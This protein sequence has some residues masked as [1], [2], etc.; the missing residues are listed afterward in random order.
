M[1]KNENTTL[2]VR[3]RITQA[4]ALLSSKPELFLIRRTFPNML[5]SDTGVSFSSDG[6]YITLDEMQEVVDWMIENFRPVKPA[7]KKRKKAKPKRSNRSVAKEADVD[8]EG[9]DD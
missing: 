8:I 9:L 5:L 2:T 3:E 6:D 4:E 1:T 7:T